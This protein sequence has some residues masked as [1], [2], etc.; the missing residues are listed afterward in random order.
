[1]SETNL[2]TP[3]APTDAPPAEAPTA[4]TPAKSPEGDE[5]LTPEYGKHIEAL[6]AG[7][8]TPTEGAK[9]LV[10]DLRA[11]AGKQDE[12]RKFLQQATQVVQSKQN[13]LVSLEGEAR[14]MVRLIKRAEGRAAQET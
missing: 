1:M 2:P 8:E 7:K 3:P 14:A 11:C 4:A 13:E 12:V 10:D 9:E 6:V 5:A